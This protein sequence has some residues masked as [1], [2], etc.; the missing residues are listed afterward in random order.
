MSHAVAAG[1]APGPRR[2]RR[3]WLAGLVMVLLA[4]VLFSAMT[5]A[6]PL[7]PGQVMAI[8]LRPLGIDLSFPFNAQEASVFWAIR[9]PRIALG[10]LVGATLAAAGASIQGLF[11]N[12]LADP[13][14]IGVSGG[15]A[16]GAVSVIVLGAG[17]LGA[18]VIG[19]A[20][21]WLGA[22]LMPLAAFVGGLGA[23]QVVVR[24]ARVQGRTTVAMMLLAGIAVNA[25]A[26]AGIGSLMFVASDAQLRSATFWTLGS[27]GGATWRTVLITAPAL[28]ACILG[29]PRLAR[30]LDLM[31]LGESEARHLGLSIERVKRIIVLLAA[32]GVG[33]AVSATGL[34]G[35]VGLVVPHVLRLL[36]GP[37]HRA[38]LPGS[39]LLGASLLVIADLVARSIVAPAELPIGIVTAVLGAP[40]FLWLLVRHGHGWVSH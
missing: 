26:G 20:A 35:F 5:G 6:V 16:L 12:P 40:L 31:L 4:A 28:L 15:A 1:I 13:G 19:S 7:T 17:G 14:L 25:L 38:L 10:A 32:L 39:A 30:A 3:S 11:R 33:A 34:I 8:A 2:A 27:V 37:G 23:T 9:L 18:G 36:L 22:V 24:L 21:G 29:V